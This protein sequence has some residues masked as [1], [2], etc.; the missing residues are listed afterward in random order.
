AV[1]S[2]AACFQLPGTVPGLVVTRLDSPALGSPTDP[3]RTQ[4]ATYDL[5]P[6]RGRD[7]CLPRGTEVAD[8]GDS[9]AVDVALPGEVQGSVD[10]VLYGT[11][12]CAG[13]NEQPARTPPHGR[14]PQ[15]PGELGASPPAP[16]EQRV[17]RRL[18]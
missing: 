6:A 11:S 1:Q 13:R 5:R 2:V 9:V 15:L 10:A 12:R 7:D 14:S 4:L 17:P 16:G 3:V 18:A 8:D